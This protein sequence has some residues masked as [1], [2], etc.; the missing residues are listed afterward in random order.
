[1]MC[2]SMLLLAASMSASCSLGGASSVLRNLSRCASKSSLV[3]LNPV[4][5]EGLFCSGLPI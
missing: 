2:D 4:A 3:T 1:M 5:V